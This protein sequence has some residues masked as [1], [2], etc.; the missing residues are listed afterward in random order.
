MKRLFIALVA[1]SALA[2]LASS[3]AAQAPKESD[4]KS[5]VPAL[6]AM[7]EVISPMWHDAWPKKD[8]AA[9]AGMA[10]K[11]E[12]HAAAIKRAPLPGVLRDKTTAWSDGVSALE[13]SVAAF[14]VAA[15]TKDDE[16]LLKAAEQVH[17]DYEGLVKV[18]RPVMKEMED[19]HASLY[20]L[21]HYTLRSNDGARLIESVKAL[22]PKME[23]LTAAALPER[24]LPKQEAFVAQRLRLSKA[25]DDAIAATAP[26]AT[27]RLIEAVERLHLEYE[28]LDKVF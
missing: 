23:T 3:S 16:A 14:R 27:D 17:T 15:D 26:G 7:H 21:Y 13:K 8:I 6:T 2:G 25:V 9:L 4:L 28:K 19:F 20:V 12:K 1:A 11:L 24:Y 22:K 5:E 18:T 10:G